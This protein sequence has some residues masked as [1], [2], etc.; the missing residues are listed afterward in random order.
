VRAVA[1]APNC[2]RGDEHVCQQAATTGLGLGAN[3]GGYAESVVVQEEMLVP[4]PDDLSLED[5]ALV[6]PLA[7]GLHGLNVG[8]ARTGDRCVVIGAGPIGVMTAF[9]LRAP[10]GTA[11]LEHAQKMFELLDDPDTQ[12]QNPARSEA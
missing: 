11:P 6:E 8:E 1:I 3:P 12:H 7:V 9:A 5:G 4:I 2:R 10:T